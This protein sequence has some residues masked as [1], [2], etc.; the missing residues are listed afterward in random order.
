MPPNAEPATETIETTETTESWLEKID[1][2]KEEDKREQ[3]WQKRFK[4]PDIQDPAA[5]D[6]VRS[7]V[8]TTDR[9]GSVG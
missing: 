1:S 4:M 7:S 6:L 5:G 8:F 3:P 2:A 9:Y